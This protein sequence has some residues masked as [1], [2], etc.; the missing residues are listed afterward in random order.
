LHKTNNLKKQIRKQFKCAEDNPGDEDSYTCAN[1]SSHCSEL[2][3]NAADKENAELRE[4]FKLLEAKYSSLE[5]ILNNLQDNFAV[6][7]TIMKQLQQL[8]AKVA[9]LQ[10]PLTEG[11]KQYENIDCWVRGYKLMA[12]TMKKHNWRLYLKT[13]AE[14]AT[15]FP[16]PVAPV[17][18]KV[19]GYERAKA[20]R[21]TLVTAPFYTS[22]SGK[23]KLQLIVQVNGYVAIN[24]ATAAPITFM[25]VHT[26]L[27]K[28]ECDDLLSWPFIGN[29]TVSLLNQIENN[30]HH[31]RAVW[32]PH[33][34]PTMEYAGRVLPTQHSNLPWGQNTF[35]SQMELESASPTRQYIMNDCLYFEVQA[36]AGLPYNCAI[37]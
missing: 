24:S 2:T 6:P 32:Q 1:D 36:S 33:D 15:Q 25:S 19:E 27:L 22:G 28:G 16:D 5:E 31:Q 10:P 34:R 26:C 37:N 20:L 17:I 3:V 9:V 11:M 29:I 7:E 18:I 13:M 23:Y 21:M 14:T 35:I 12:E 8:E 30:Q 4:S